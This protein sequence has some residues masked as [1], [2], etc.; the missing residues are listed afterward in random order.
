MGCFFFL[1]S[2]FKNS[3][4]KKERRKRGMKRERERGRKEI[5]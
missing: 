1:F 2:L 5:W 3:L 4:I